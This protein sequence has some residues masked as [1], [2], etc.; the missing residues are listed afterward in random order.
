MG[1]GDPKLQKLLL[2]LSRDYPGRMMLMNG[3]D[4]TLAHRIYATADIFLMPSRY[5]PCGLGQMIAMRYGAIPVARRTGGLADTID[6]GRTGFLFDEYSS[7]A[8]LRESA[9][10]WLHGPTEKH[11][12]R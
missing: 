2:G 9:K 8:L 10:H 1:K 11:G 7:T 6:H 12:K 5:E 4:E 3:F